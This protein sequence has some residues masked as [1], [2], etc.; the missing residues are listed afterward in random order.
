MSGPPA[1]AA[2]S[3]VR[4]GI[5]ESLPL[6]LALVPVGLAFGY[7]A[8]TAGLS[9]WLAGLMSAIVYA[10]PSQFIAMGLVGTG[11]SVPAITSAKAAPI[12]VYDSPSRHD[13]RPSG[14]GRAVSA[15]TR[16]SRSSKFVR[17]ATPP[18]PPQ[19]NCGVRPVLTQATGLL[20]PGTT[21]HIDK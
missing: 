1:R 12:R 17:I 18:G 10:G 14:S 16:A 15:F 20:R 21:L 3:E 6:G 7:L 9:W 11:A 8:H 13:R 19:S 4:A 2:R 5:V